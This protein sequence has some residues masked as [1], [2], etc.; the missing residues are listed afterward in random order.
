MGG[1]QPARVIASGFFAVKN[2]LDMSLR[3]PVVE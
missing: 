1:Y 2:V 3:G